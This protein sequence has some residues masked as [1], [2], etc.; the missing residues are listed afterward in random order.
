MCLD[1]REEEELSLK[2]GVFVAS[3]SQSSGQVAYGQS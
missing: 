1:A 2:I 3:K